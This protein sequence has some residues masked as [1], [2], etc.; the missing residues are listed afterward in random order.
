MEVHDAPERAPS[1]GPNMLPL[2]RLAGL[3]TSLRD[4][5]ALVHKTELKNAN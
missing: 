5:H 4:I 3:L 2:N 1:D